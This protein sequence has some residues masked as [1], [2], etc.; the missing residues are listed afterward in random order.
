MIEN[1][2]PSD[3]RCLQAS[4][5]NIL[6]E[7][8][9]HSE[10]EK[11][12]ETPRGEVEIDVFGIDQNSVEQIRYIIECKNWQSAVPQ[13]VVHAF[14]T[15]LQETGG[16]IGMLISKEGFQEG[17][18]KYIKHTNIVA[19]TFAEFQERYFKLWYTKNFCT[20]LTASV[21][22][23]LQY[24]EPIN[25]RRSRYLTELDSTKIEQY[26]V[27]RERYET[28]AMVTAMLAMDKFAQGYEVSA[29]FDIE[30]FK[31]KMV[32]NF[33]EEFRYQSIYYRDLAVEISVHIKEITE[34]FN[35]VFGQN[36]FS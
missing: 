26:S 8:G 16:H 30:D 21:D 11:T 28:F 9:I 25:S 34:K 14:T 2:K 3:W 12:L 18:L 15:V 13:T 4:V 23:L 6:N 32:D 17:A 7:V 33:G 24:V 1:P 19:L 5:C 36:I 27:L 20:Q 35:Q 10:T 31:N 29:L 22:T